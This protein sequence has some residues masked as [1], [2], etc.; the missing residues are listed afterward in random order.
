MKAKYKKIIACSLAAAVIAAVSAYTWLPGTKTVAKQ[1]VKAT[2]AAAA[3]YLSTETVDASNIRQ[4][5]TA[6]STTSRTFM[7]QSDYAE[8]KPV[9]NTAKPATILPSCSSP[10]PATPSATMA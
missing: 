1:G 3:H 9:V 6:D 2:K 4:V 7:W 5:I 10:L 8:D